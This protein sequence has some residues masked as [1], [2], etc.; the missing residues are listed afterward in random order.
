M[1]TRSLVL[2][3]AMYVALDLTNPFIPGAF[4]FD[5]EESVE[6]ISTERSWKAAVV[7]PAPIVPRVERAKPLPASPR[8]RDPRA[9]QRSVEPGPAH[10]RDP[11]PPPL[12]DEH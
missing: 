2:A 7:F 1:P 5:P 9:R 8:L 10:V 11:E 3:I 12:S 6:G 4:H